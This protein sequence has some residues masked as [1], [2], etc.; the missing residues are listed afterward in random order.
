M[1]ERLSNIP[2][3]RFELQ[4]RILVLHR[5]I[6]ELTHTAAKINDID[7][8]DTNFYRF[9]EVLDLVERGNKITGEELEERKTGW[10][11]FSDPNSKQ[12][13]FIQDNYGSH[14]EE[15][16]KRI[17]FLS[18]LLETQK[19]D[20]QTA[21][22]P[23]KENFFCNG[24][25][26]VVNNYLDPEKELKEMPKNRILIITQTYPNYVPYMKKAK[27]VVSEVG[28]ISSHAAIVSRELETPCIVGTKVATKIFKSGDKVEMNLE[29][30]VI[31]KIE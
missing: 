27:A 19:I 13:E 10:A 5:I 23:D 1:L 17:N 3:H 20:G 6:Q 21:S 29:N 4:S 18:E 16:R 8:N 25:A 11:F 2:R 9:K 14:G 24:E 15:V 26:Y 12:V 22:F 7:K 28:G 31:K 30:G